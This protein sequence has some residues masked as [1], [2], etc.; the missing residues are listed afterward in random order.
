MPAAAEQASEQ[1]GALGSRYPRMRDHKA[2]TTQGN[3]DRVFAMLV[4]NVYATRGFQRR[5][6]LEQGMRSWFNSGEAKSNR[7]TLCGRYWQFDTFI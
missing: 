4:L 7:C 1:E 6:M 2:L 5:S 3:G